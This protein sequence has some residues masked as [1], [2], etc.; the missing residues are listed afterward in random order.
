MVAPDVPSGHIE[1]LPPA[2]VQNA[3]SREL[4]LSH[5]P[6]NVMHTALRDPLMTSPERIF[7]HQSSAPSA[8]LSHQVATTMSTSHG[9]HVFPVPLPPSGS[10]QV[11]LTPQTQSALNM[12]APNASSTF[13]ALSAAAT[14]AALHSLAQASSSY[15][16]SHVQSFVTPDTGLQLNVS[17]TGSCGNHAMASAGPVLSAHVAQSLAQGSLGVVTPGTQGGAFAVPHATH[18]SAS[19]AGECAL[20]IFLCMLPRFLS[21]NSPYCCFVCNYTRLYLVSTN[22]NEADTINVLYC[23][24]FFDKLNLFIC[25][26]KGLSTNRGS[27]LVIKHRLPKA[28]F[29]EEV[30]YCTP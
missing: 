6:H 25:T 8:A 28:H 4:V 21:E 1:P 14:N 19:T 12:S 20:K 11:R 18:G 7:G 30:T 23:V 24:R 15:S 22:E 16:L 13:P 26:H 5:E 2:Q 29:F 9:Q 27:T 10:N 17:T 3:P